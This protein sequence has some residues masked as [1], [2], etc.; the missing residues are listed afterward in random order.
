MICFTGAVSLHSATFGQGDGPIYLDSVMCMGNES[1]LTECQHQGIGSH[2]CT[3]SEDA[4]AVCPSESCMHM[5]THTLTYIHTHPRT[6]THPHTHTH[7][8]THTHAQPLTHTHT[9]THMDIDAN[10]TE[11]SVLLDYITRTTVGVLLDSHIMISSVGT[12]Y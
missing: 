1:N 2:D 3:H 6:T 9:H 8:H 11:E 4:G 5:H 7:T 10:N 12:T